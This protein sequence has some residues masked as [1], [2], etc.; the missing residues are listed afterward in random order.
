MNY[1]IN[2]VER[3][4]L[5]SLQNK[6]KT[7]MEIHS[8]TSIDKQI[9]Q[10]VLESLIAKNIVTTMDGKYV[11]NKNISNDIRGELNNSKDIKIEFTEI[12]NSTFN[13]KKDDSVLKLKKVHMNEKEEKIFK[14]LLYNVESFLTGLEKKQDKLSKQQVIFWGEANYGKIINN[15]INC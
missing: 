2:L 12:L 9:I 4:L 13:L 14:G 11:I 8:C 15:Y 6:P 7:A 10:G 3:L 5:E 1:N